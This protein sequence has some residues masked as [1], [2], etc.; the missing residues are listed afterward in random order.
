MIY[1][2]IN[3]PIVRQRKG[4]QT[5]QVYYGHTVGAAVGAHTHTTLPGIFLRRTDALIQHQLTGGV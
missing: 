3:W 4:L 5:Q 1:P 2:L